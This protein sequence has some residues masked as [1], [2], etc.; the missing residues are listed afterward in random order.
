MADGGISSEVQLSLNDLALELQSLGLKHGFKD[1]CNTT[2]LSEYLLS[3]SWELINLVH[4]TVLGLNDSKHATDREALLISENQTLESKLSSLRDQLDAKEKMLV[5]EKGT[6]F[7]MEVE[8]KKLQDSIQKQ[9]QQIAQLCSR[10]GSQERDFHNELKKQEAQIDAL[11]EIVRK[12]VGIGR[13]HFPGHVERLRSGLGSL[14]LKE[15]LSDE[16]VL[17]QTTVNRLKSVNCTLVGENLMLRDALKLIHSDV[18]VVLNLTGASQPA[19]ARKVPEAFPD[20]MFQMP[21]AYSMKKMTAIRQ[22]QISKLFEIVRSRSCL[23]CC[24]T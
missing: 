18:N 3:T 20:N 6:M 21:L 4:C 5:S 12:S 13:N 11:R 10:L 14:E 19:A 24:P 7:R 16:A 9:K 15:R 17:Q 22:D 2:E 8:Q 1:C 23:N